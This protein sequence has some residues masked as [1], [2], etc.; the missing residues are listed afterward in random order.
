MA[1]H[2]ELFVVFSKRQNLLAVSINPYRNPAS[3]L[4]K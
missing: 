4:R 3:T 2:V 1:M